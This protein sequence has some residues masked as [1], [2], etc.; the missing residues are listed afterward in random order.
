MRSKLRYQNQKKM[1][2]ISIFLALDILIIFGLLK[3]SNAVYVADAVGEAPMDVALYAF[4]YDGL[5]NVQT[6][7][8]ETAID[9]NLGSLQPNKKDSQNQYPEDGKKTY[10]FTVTNRM[11][12][13]NDELVKTDTNISY[14]L[15]VIVTTNIRLNYGLYLNQNPDVAGAVNL[16]R[17]NG[18]D[19]G[20][21]SQDSWGT[22]F[23]YY[24]L[25]EKCLTKD[26]E[27]SDDYYLTVE[28]PE[29]MIDSKYQDLVESIK[30]QL[31]SKQVL[32]EDAISSSGLCR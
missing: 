8:T 19:N 5:Y 1:N 6:G 15:K 26:R 4:K 16:L 23:K 14:K 9:I 11:L 2:F 28:F 18:S 27:V 24:T 12:N 29:D 20:V 10:H 32:P 3:T 30:I 13:D 21:E 31:E 25:D 7:G 22:Y 17:T